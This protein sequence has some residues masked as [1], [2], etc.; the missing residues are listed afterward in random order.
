MATDNI[1]AKITLATERYLSLKPLATKEARKEMSKIMNELA[2]YFWKKVE[3]T[4][5]GALDSHSGELIFDQSDLLIVDSGLLDERLVDGNVESLKKALFNE[6]TAEGEPNHYYLSEL[7]KE[8]HRQFVVYDKMADSDTEA[9]VAEEEKSKYS[10]MTIVRDKIYDRIRP[11][12][13]GL[14]GVSAQI[15]DFIC[16]G[17]LDGQIEQLSSQ[18]VEARSENLLKQRNQLIQIRDKVLN[19][20]KTRCKSPKE[21]ELIE[22]LN[23]LNNDIMKEIVKVKT[24][25]LKASG[26]RSGKSSSASVAIDRQSMEKSINFLIKE[27]RL[28][29]S[30]RSIGIISGGMIHAQYVLLADQ[31]RTDKKRTSAIMRLIKEVDPQ[32]PGN[33]DLV[34]APYLGN[35]HMRF[36][37]D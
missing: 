36:I 25:E 3:K 26:G 8:R 29:K 31:Q 20:V 33:P 15:A 9:L 24:R 27:V 21:L 6:F 12:F 14:P 4:I 34:I 19:Q 22:G 13:M 18:Y 1:D 30:L 37:Q 2:D 32:L 16:S 5:T 17:K 7:I 35:G 28:M 10:G 11:F 23:S